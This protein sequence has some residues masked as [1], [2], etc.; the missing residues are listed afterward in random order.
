VRALVA[1]LALVACGP[2]AKPPP[3][4]PP[5]VAAPPVAPSSVGWVPYTSADG[6]FTIQFPGTPEE[7]SRDYG[8]GT[9]HV[10]I[11]GA[12]DGIYLVTWFVPSPTEARNPTL[13]FDNVEAGALGQGAGGTVV[14][15]ADITL[16]G[17]YPGRAL[18]VKLAQPDATMFVR[19]FVAG[20]RVY[21][22]SALG[23]KDGAD[24]DDSFFDSFAVTN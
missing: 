24:V 16:D 9:V 5:P 18:T 23:K 21:Q 6:R 4:A 8:D 10:V 14:A 1:T 15:R 2:A 20:D 13:V 3:A 19:C 17:T 7:S 22:L 11:H 12:E